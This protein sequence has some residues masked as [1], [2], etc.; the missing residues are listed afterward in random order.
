MAF[1]RRRSELLRE[2]GVVRIKSGFMETLCAPMNR[3]AR[4][5]P[6]ETTFK[7]HAAVVMCIPAVPRLADETQRAPRDVG[8]EDLGD[9]TE[10]GVHERPNLG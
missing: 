5:P 6:T 1:T 10:V 2:L 9:R 8:V 3:P 7:H 4:I